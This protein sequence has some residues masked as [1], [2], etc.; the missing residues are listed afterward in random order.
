M[1][2]VYGWILLG[3]LLLAGG[4]GAWLWASSGEPAAGPSAGPSSSPSPVPPAFSVEVTLR[5]VK[6]IPVRGSVK[7]RKLRAPA[8]EVRQTFTDL[9]AAAFVDPARWDGGAFP[10]IFGHFAPAA[11]AEARQHLDE[12]TLGRANEYVSAVRPEWARL[13]VR[14]LLG[15]A[16]VPVA[17]QASMRFAATAFNDDGVEVPIRHRG[18]YMLERLEGRW[19]VT[20]YRVNGG[21]GPEAV[22]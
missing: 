4:L 5:R 7:A 22:R 13:D 15:P 18:D 19:L 14:F 12:L 1:S 2:R 17:A 20:S 6:A 21:F 8:E 10:G 3:L 9:Y 11:R 16:R